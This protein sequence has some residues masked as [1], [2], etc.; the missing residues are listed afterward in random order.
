M[1]SP[2][3]EIRTAKRSWTLEYPAAGLD[4]QKSSYFSVTT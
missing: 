3:L 1:N 4:I 2:L